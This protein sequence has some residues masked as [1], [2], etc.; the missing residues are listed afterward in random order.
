MRTWFV[1]S[2][3]LVALIAMA[4]ANAQGNKFRVYAAFN[5]LSP[6]GSSDLSIDSFVER[7]EASQEAGWS[8]GLECAS[9]S[10]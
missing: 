4:P 7:I 5:Y 1:L 10:T 2:V 9:A 6:T 3:S 8:V